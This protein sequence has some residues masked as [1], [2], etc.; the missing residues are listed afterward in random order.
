MRALQEILINLVLH[1]SI[2]GV[3]DIFSCGLLEFHLG[4]DLEVLR[5]VIA[6]IGVTLLCQKINTLFLVRAASIH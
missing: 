2:Q 3:S 4:L 6:F 5:L 1:K